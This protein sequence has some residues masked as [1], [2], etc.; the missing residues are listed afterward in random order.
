M[1]EV[2]A[3]IYRSEFGDYYLPVEHYT[4]DEALEEVADWI[5][6]L[7]DAQKM[8]VGIERIPLHKHS[9]D[10]DELYECPNY[11]DEVGDEP[12]P[13]IGYVDCHVFE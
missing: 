4:K 9:M 7:E 3:L 11:D 2:Q 6:D 10:G 8:Y 13:C 1:S 5:G 12:G